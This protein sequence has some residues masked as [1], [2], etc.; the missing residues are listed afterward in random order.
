VRVLLDDNVATLSAWFGPPNE[1][2]VELSLSRAVAEELCK[3][4]LLLLLW[5]FLT[6][7]KCFGVGVGE[8]PGLWR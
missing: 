8:G 2:D 5:L 3:L 1:N 7:M 4:M 6:A